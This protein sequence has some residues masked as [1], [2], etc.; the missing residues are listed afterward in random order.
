MGV[1]EFNRQKCDNIMFDMYNSKYGYICNDCFDE[2]LNSDVP[3]IAEGITSFFPSNP[4]NDIVARK[5]CLNIVFRV[6]K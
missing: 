6:N 5:A 2:L 1:R 3:L 4:Q